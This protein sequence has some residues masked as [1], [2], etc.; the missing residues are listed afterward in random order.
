MSSKPIDNNTT[1]I[2]PSSSPTEKK[3]IEEK[4]SSLSEKILPGAGEPLRAKP[5][6]ITPLPKTI[7]TLPDLEIP[8]RLTREQFIDLFPPGIRNS[9]FFKVVL[10][11]VWEV[12]PEPFSGTKGLGYGFCIHPEIIGGIISWIKSLPHTP[13]I[14]EVGAGL[15]LKTLLFS[16]ARADTKLYINDLPDSGLK[17]CEKYAAKMT[18]RKQNIHIMPRDCLEFLDSFEQPET[19]DCLLS[20]SVLQFLT[21]KDVDLFLQKAFEKLKPGAKIVISLQGANRILLE[22]PTLDISPDSYFINVQVKKLC[23]FIPDG[24]GGFSKEILSEDVV[25]LPDNAPSLTKENLST[26]KELI[27]FSKQEQN[28]GWQVEDPLQKIEEWFSDSQKI[29]EIKTGF[30]RMKN[31][32]ANSEEVFLEKSYSS[33]ILPDQLSRLATDHG[34]VNP[35]IYPIDQLG[36]NM[37]FSEALKSRDVQFFCLIAKKPDEIKKSGT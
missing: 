3:P 2:P 31:S 36:H 4:T 17:T 11:K 1:R 18:D 27:L 28:R 30:S 21:A 8:S 35:M 24:K 5:I 6:S 7:S 14:A 34:F 37:N 20:I 13:N 12:N 33:A 26:H 15:G 16:L 25:A 10:E 29:N 19:L 9:K 23:S 32:L 22:N